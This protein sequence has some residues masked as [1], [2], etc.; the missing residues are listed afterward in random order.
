MVLDNTVLSMVLIQYAG[1]VVL[2]YVMVLNGLDVGSVVLPWS[3][4]NDFCLVVLCP[5]PSLQVMTSSS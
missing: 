1:Y 5:L 4:K 2:P 3:K